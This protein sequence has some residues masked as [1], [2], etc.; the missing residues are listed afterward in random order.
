MDFLIFTIKI[1]V[2]TLLGSFI[3]WQRHHMGK[4]AGI[5][6]FALVT[7][8]CALFTLLSITAF[9]SN[10]SLIAAQIL[11]G[12]GFLGAGT[13][14][15]KRATV[16][17]LTTAASLWAAASIGMAVGVGWYWQATLASILMFLI[18]SFKSKKKWYERQ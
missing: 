18:L 9:G 15:H 11:T 1:I 7:L 2:A 4:A 8:G 12:V 14:I 16:E 13:I 5:R 3:G 17:G 10:T 6:T